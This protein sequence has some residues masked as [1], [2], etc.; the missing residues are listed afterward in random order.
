MQLVRGKTLD[1][2]IPPTAGLL[3]DLSAAGLS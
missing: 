2:L 1:Q 3:D